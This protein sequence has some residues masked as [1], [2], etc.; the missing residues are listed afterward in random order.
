MATSYY[1]GNNEVLESSWRRCLKG[2]RL[3]KS[4][5]AWKNH[6]CSFF[7]IVNVTLNLASKRKGFYNIVLY[8]FCCDFFQNPNICYVNTDQEVLLHFFFEKR[9]AWMSSSL[10]KNYIVDR[11]YK[12][13][14]FVFWELH[15]DAWI[16]KS[17]PW[18]WRF[19]P[20]DWTRYL[21]E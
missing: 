18:L 1:G 7:G 2:S 4:G 11:Q 8:F 12:F 21:Y 20:I 3:E 9:N 15:I 14:S 6:P 17:L 16:G 19:D 10:M 5:R 13:I